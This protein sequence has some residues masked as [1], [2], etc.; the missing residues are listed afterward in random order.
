LDIRKGAAK[1]TSNGITASWINGIMV[2]FES[3]PVS[4]AELPAEVEHPKAILLRAYHAHLRSE[5]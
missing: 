2:P 3:H 5:I 4:V 1:N